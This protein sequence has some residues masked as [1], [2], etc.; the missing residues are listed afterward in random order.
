MGVRRAHVSR[1]TSLRVYCCALRIEPV[2]LS[3]CRKKKSANVT[4]HE[5]GI[6]MLQFHFSIRICYQFLWELLR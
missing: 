4:P 2:A 5:H 3:Q 1:S 6:R